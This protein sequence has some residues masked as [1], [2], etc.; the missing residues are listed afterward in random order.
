MDDSGRGED[1]DPV[2]DETLLENESDD[3]GFEVASSLDELDLER[4]D[5]AAERG[6]S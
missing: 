1:S 6:E 4:E 3:F 2:V 5:R